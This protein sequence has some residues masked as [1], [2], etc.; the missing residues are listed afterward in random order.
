[1]ACH[2]KKHVLIIV[3]NLPLPFDRRV[4][5]EANTL[6]EAGYGVSIICP[7]GE[8]PYSKEYECINEINI[9]RHNLP[10]EAKGPVAYLLEY[11]YSMKYE[12]KLADYIFK[13]HGFD[14]I[15]ACNPPDLI[16]LIAKKYK[17][18]HNVKFIFDH[19]DINPELYLA[20]FGRKDLFYRM[21]L[22]FER[23]TFKNADHC[24]ATNE[25][26]KKIAVTRGGKNPDDVT[27]VRSGPSVERLYKVPVD[28]N[29]K[30]GKKFLIGYIGVIGQQE[31]IPYILEAAKIIKEEHGR[32]DIQFLIMGKGPVLE[33][34]RKL[35]KKM[36][37]EDCVA[38]PGIVT[39]DYLRT[40]L[41][42]SDVC[43]NSDKYNEMND[44]STMNKIM[45]YMAI[46]KPIVQFDLLEGRNSAGEAS[47]YAEPN[48]VYDFAEKI[49]YLLDRPEERERM[50][51]LGEE[52]IMNEL[53][54][55]FQAP[56]LLEAYEKVF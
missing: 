43:V 54:W 56:K 30:N 9:Y 24:I 28:E 14:V 53:N 40:A 22:F 47:L 29:L 32:S 2:G 36:G 18:K 55:D 20:K 23:Q 49:L 25:S 45:E 38:L 46:G 50:G 10:V 52:R 51:K 34:M 37:L 15:Q 11:Y 6:K 39:D 1:M 42:T 27:I 44:K 8:A 17:R 21:L 3:Q 5:Q 7:K 19:H 16:Y 26:Y 33:E 48:D 35:N 41:S 4:W 12:R 13:N 31:G